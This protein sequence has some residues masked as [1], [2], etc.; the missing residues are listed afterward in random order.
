MEKGKGKIFLNTVLWGF[1]LWLYGYILGFVFFAIVPK[2]QIGWYIFPFGLAAILWVL[3]R[4]IK[5]DEFKC[6][7]GLGI[8]WTV[9]A[10]VLDY[11]FLVKMLSAT[12][13]YKLDVYMYYVLTLT[14]PILVGVNKIK[15]SN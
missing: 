6:F 9:L 5:R 1:A 3:V 14:L 12:N 15:R 10:I 4:K 13:Y 11:V 7:I 2:D 8:V